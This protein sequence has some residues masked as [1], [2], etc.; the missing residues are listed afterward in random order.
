MLKKLLF[1]TVLLLFV[2]V[3]PM[4]ISCDLG[5]SLMSVS[6]NC[7]AV[8]IDERMSHCHD[9]AVEQD[10]QASVTASDSCAHTRCG[11]ELTAITKSFDQNSVGPSKLLISASGLWVGPSGSCGPTKA[12]ALAALSPKIGS[13]PLTQSPGSSLRI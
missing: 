1:V 10:K 2:S 9:I 7:H 8:Q 6:T 4:T 12:V 5:C 13:R 11:T 3:Q